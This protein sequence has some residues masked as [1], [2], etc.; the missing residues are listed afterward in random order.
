M[1]PYQPVPL[2]GFR[3]IDLT[4]GPG[5]EHHMMDVSSGLCEFLR[6][7]PVSDHSLH[8]AVHLNLVRVGVELDQCEPVDLLDDLADDH[9]LGQLGVERHEAGCY[10]WAVEQIQA[11]VWRHHRAEA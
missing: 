1:E 9:W 6:R 5:G 3:V 10:S 8:E 7:H 2:P 11:D 4:V